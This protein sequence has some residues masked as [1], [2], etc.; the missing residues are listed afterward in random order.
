MAT[1][2]LK[3]SIISANELF[4]RYFAAVSRNNKNR[5]QCHACS[6]QLSRRGRP[7]MI[8]SR[9]CSKTHIRLFPFGRYLHVLN[10]LA[11]K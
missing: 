11:K 4:N 9:M 1:Q 5:Q 8:F 7:H 6:D 10:F 2:G 3:F